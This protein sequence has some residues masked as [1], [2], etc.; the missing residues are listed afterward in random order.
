MISITVAPTHPSPSPSTGPGPTHTGSSASS[1]MMVILFAAVFL[2]LIFILAAL[3]VL[4][5]VRRYRRSSITASDR[6]LSISTASGDI[7]AQ[8]GRDISF[9]EKTQESSGISALYVWAFSGSGRRSLVG[10][11]GDA[12]PLPVLASSSAHG[13]TLS[14]RLTSAVCSSLKRLHLKFKVLLCFVVYG[15]NGCL[16]LARKTWNTVN[17]YD[18]DLE[19]DR[20]IPRPFYIGEAPRIII[21]RPSDEDIA[22]EAS[23]P[24]STYSE[25]D[26]PTMDTP[27]LG[28][29]VDVY[30]YEGS[31]EGDRASTVQVAG[32]V[33]DHPDVY[34]SSAFAPSSKDFLVTAYGFGFQSYAEQEE[35]GDRLIGAFIALLSSESLSDCIED[36]DDGDGSEEPDEAHLEDTSEYLVEVEPALK[37]ANSCATIVQWWPGSSPSCEPYL[38]LESYFDGTEENSG[39]LDADVSFYSCVGTS[40]VGD[41]AGDLRL[42]C[43]T[44]ISPSPSGEVYYDCYG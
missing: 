29:P 42:G 36:G 30:I 27:V 31:I 6:T 1:P 8:A 28:S 26:S 23:S 7:E 35:K 12:L 2:L 22:F 17:S 14:S 24:A 9:T 16:A 18:A 40:F 39:H 5:V 21:T 41:K 37:H 4:A 13:A 33:E 25:P 10:T 19:A 15:V 38:A 34:G 11:P 44:T 3:S 20:L 43:G 32:Q